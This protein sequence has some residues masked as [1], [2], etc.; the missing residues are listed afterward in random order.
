MKDKKI[1][2]VAAI[3]MVL[4]FLFLKWLDNSEVGNSVEDSS[5]RNTLQGS[6]GQEDSRRSQA[7]S[8]RVKP[9][10]AEPT[11]KFHAIFADLTPEKMTAIREALKLNPINPT[12]GPKENVASLKTGNEA[13]N[14]LARK[15][16]MA[17]VPMKYTEDDEMFYFS[18]GILAE[19]VFD[20]STGYA[21]SKKSRSI[22]GWSIR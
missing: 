2:L 15:F 1:V 9:I 22:A 3:V 18:G 8:E 14:L 7:M 11:Y 12:A 21:V 16:G 19:K 13:L 4:G 20:F 10:Q 6:R 5:R 17:F